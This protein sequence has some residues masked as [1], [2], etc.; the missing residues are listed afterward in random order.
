MSDGIDLRVL[1]LLCG[2]LC[3][4]LVSPIGAVNN[5]VELLD[6]DDPEFVKE[7]M[8]LIGQSAKKAGQR[9]Q[10]YRFAYG[11]AAASAARAD[12]AQPIPHELCAGLL[13]G[14]KV[15]AHWAPDAL[16]L[17]LPWQRLACNMLVLAMEAL[18]R[19]GGVGVRAAGGGVEVAADGD[20]APLSAEAKAALEGEGGSAALTNR[21]V[22]AFYTARLAAELG[23]RLALS[24]APQRLLLAAATTG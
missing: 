15:R 21:T 8:A 7:A 13:D 14:G 11:S 5:G 16:A 22:H 23:A 20:V 17:P 1:E 4:E 9:L 18:P 24:T 19:G 10:F 2:R 3:H 12:G 6:E